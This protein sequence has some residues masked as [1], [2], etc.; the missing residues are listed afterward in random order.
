MRAIYRFECHHF[1]VIFI[2]LN[3]KETTNGVHLKMFMAE[4]KISTTFKRNDSSHSRNGEI[5]L[6]PK[7]KI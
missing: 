1:G 4:T 5:Q 7:F 3:Y 6:E 2:L